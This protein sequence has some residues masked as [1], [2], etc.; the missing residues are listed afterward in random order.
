MYMRGGKIV[1]F[2]TD[3]TVGIGKCTCSQYANKPIYR[4]KKFGLLFLIRAS[5]AAKE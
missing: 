2:C 5:R 4:G 3:L 1:P